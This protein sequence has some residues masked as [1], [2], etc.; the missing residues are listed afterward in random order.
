MSLKP[1]KNHVIVRQIKKASFD[2]TI[3]AQSDAHQ[4]FSGEGIVESIGVLSQE[5]EIAVG[6][7]VFFPKY[8]GTKLRDNL[9][10]LVYWDID[11][12]LEE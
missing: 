10:L 1:T 4:E 8:A 3:I 7:H 12:V 2:S 5:C 11:G 9:L 6:D